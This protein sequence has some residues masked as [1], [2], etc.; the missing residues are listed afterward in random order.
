MRQ[1]IRDVISGAH[2]PEGG[3]SA[4]DECDRGIRK[5]ELFEFEL[6][7]RLFLRPFALGDLLA[8]RARMLA[9]ESFHD[10]FAERRFLRVADYHPRP[11]YC[12]QKGP[13]QA[14]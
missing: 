3:W 10:R 2:Y 13:V 1:Q 8:K 5:F 14:D 9:V 12:L 11:G 6:V 4:E 7:V